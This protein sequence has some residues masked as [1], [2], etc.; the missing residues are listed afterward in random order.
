MIYVVLSYASL[1]LQVKHLRITDIA[2]I[3]PIWQFRG[4][5]R[6]RLPRADRFGDHIDDVGAPQP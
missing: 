2:I 6:V 1:L 4:L 5:L 3:S